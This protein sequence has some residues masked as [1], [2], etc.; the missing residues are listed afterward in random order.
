MDAGISAA[1]RGARRGGEKSIP[2]ALQAE[3]KNGLPPDAV[4]EPGRSLRREIFRVRGGKSGE[5]LE[6]SEQGGAFLA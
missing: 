4:C 2:G 3:Q 1:E 6:F 5:G